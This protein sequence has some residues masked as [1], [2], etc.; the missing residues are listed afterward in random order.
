MC[1]MSNV[2]HISVVAED[3]HAVTWVFFQGKAP[4][5]VTG[6]AYEMKIVDDVDVPALT[7]TFATAV[8]ANEVECIGD[9]STLNHT[10]EYQ[11]QLVE[12]G[13]AILS[14]TVSVIPR[15]A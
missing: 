12:E 15:F 13:N 1:G 7:V 14:G 6:R 3:N 8:S 9:C 11:Y 10:V 2:A 4:F 5:D